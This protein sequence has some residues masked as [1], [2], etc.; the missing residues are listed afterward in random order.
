MS[1]F[2]SSPADINSS[3]GI[4]RWKKPDDNWIKINVDTV[5]QSNGIG[6]GVGCV[7]RILTASYLLP[8]LVFSLLRRVFSVR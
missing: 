3:F 5:W 6:I 2:D 7:I 8:A 1:L 4:S